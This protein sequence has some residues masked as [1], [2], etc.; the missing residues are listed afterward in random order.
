METHYV[1]SQLRWAREERIMPV[2]PVS[3][4]SKPLVRFFP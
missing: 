4:F 1:G 3:L 2:T